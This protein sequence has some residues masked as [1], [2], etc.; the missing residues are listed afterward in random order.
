M[1]RHGPK[2]V[3]NNLHKELPCHFQYTTLFLKEVHM[4]LPLN[5]KCGSMEHASHHQ[6][7]FQLERWRNK[8][9]P[10]LPLLA[11]MKK[12]RMKDLHVYLRSVHFNSSFWTSSFN[13][14]SLA[15]LNYVL[16]LTNSVLPSCFI[17]L[18]CWFKKLF[19]FI[20]LHCSKFG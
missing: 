4:H 7:H 9:L 8:K 20:Y 19:N 1:K 6:M 15:S 2:T 11:F 16:D 12:L 3:C 18:K 13:I 5:A 17:C 14:H 10:R